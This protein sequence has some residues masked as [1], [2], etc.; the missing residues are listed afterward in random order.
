MKIKYCLVLILM[1][2]LILCSVK[3]Q[4]DE[5]GELKKRSFQV[6]FITPIGTN[7]VYSG[8]YINEL[9]LNVLAGYNGGLDG[10]EIGG[11]LNIIKNNA[12]GFQGAGFANIVFGSLNGAQIAGTAN[13]VNDN[14]EGLQISGFANLSGGSFNGLQASGFG[15]VAE[16]NSDIIQISGF[17]NITSGDI[18]GLQIG[19]FG[20]ISSNI[21]G[22]QLGGFINITE[23]ING[24]QISGFMNI[25]EEAEG[26]QLGFLN[27]CDTI[28]GIPIGFLS[29]V[30]KGINTFEF[31]GSD[32]LHVNIAYK[33]GVKKFYNIIAA[34]SH[35]TSGF[36]WAIGYGIGS[37]FNIGENT[38]FNL[39]AISFNIH[40]NFRLNSNVNLNQLRI[41][42]GLEFYDDKSFFVG[43]T[44]NVLVSDESYSSRAISGE[45]APYYFSNRNTRYGTNV[46]MWI[47]IN[48]G[49]RF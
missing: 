2:L 26:I 40:D 24:A 11:C 48:A 35:F 1:H 42:Y 49:V 38:I 17:G 5:K 21:E 33:T 44:F 8:R 12:E 25:A 15:N 23:E 19:G 4:E 31:W 14:S 47:G 45:I 10:F 9:S 18:T 34:G 36:K 30:K 43:P 3:A 37:Q 32:A 16:G 6:T 46:K 28:D 39:E 22:A 13:M 29:F 20:N 41:N 7:G 27:F